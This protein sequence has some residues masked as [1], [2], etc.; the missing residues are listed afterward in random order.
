MSRGPRPRA[1][2]GAPWDDAF[3]RRSPLFW[4]IGAAAARLAGEPTFP[5]P[6]RLDALFGETAGVR[7][8]RAAPKPGRRAR[9]RGDA[10]ELY[11][12]RIVERGEVPTRAASWHDL[13]NALVWATFP[14]AKRAIHA[15][16]HALVVPAAPGQVV[17]RPRALDALALFDEGGVAVV[18]GEDRPVLFGHALY[19]GLVEGWGGATA[20]ALR[21]PA[22]RDLAELDVALAAIIGDE[23]RFHD[24]SA[25]TR[26]DLGRGVMEG[27]AGKTELA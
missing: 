4:P 5:D 26:F 24:P 10:A 25:L 8:V 23:A 17:H 20:S 11:D 14:R 3:A 18:A 9:R 15:R 19:E 6:E 13:L 7:F 16:Q 21:V 22:A 27:Q 12:A 2:R 1:P